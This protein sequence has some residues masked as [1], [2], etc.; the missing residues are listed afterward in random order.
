MSVIEP[1]GGAAGT[2]LLADFWGARTIVSVAELDALVRAAVESA[3]ARLLDLAFHQFPAAKRG[4]AAIEPAG[5]TAAVP[6]GI[7]G[8]ALLAESHIS[9]HTWPERGYV[10]VDVFMCGGQRPETA[11]EVM[12]RAFAPEREQVHTVRRGVEMPHDAETEE[13][14][15]DVGKGSSRDASGTPATGMRVA[16]TPLRAVGSR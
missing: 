12:R 14:G 8:Y 13:C 9:V 16:N 1:E 5:G 7:T 2:H 4:P 11:L 6:G 10:A 15:T 3:G